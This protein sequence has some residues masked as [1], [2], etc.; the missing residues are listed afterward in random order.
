LSAF[1]NVTQHVEIVFLELIEAAPAGFIR[2]YG[3]R[4]HPVAA[5]VLVK[6]DTRLD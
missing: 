4:L 3:I 1:E 2:W 6:V 5:C